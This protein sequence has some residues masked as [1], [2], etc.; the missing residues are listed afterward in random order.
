M[1]KGGRG[2][3]VNDNFFGNLGYA[4]MLGN[5]EQNPVPFF[6]QRKLTDW[7]GGKEVRG[8][9]IGTQKVRITI[10][11]ASRNI[12]YITDVLKSWPRCS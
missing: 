2:K 10:P 11:G 4:R 8:F 9:K 1:C 7:L 6:F 3:V 5:V 12:T